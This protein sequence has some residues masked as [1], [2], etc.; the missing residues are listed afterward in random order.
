MTEGQQALQ[1]VTGFSCSHCYGSHLLYH[2]AIGLHTCT[3]CAPIT[4]NEKERLKPL[5]EAALLFQNQDIE[6]E[7]DCARGLVLATMQRPVRNVT[8]AMFLGVGEREVKAIIK[9]LRDD[10]H[11]PIGSL[12]EPPYGYYWINSP[13]EF[14]AW[15]EPMRSQAMSELRTAYRLMRRHYPHLAGQFTFNFDQE[16]SPNEEQA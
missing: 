10:W 11:L 9:T 13:E 8:L 6:K 1:L 3:A 2:A 5:F 7:F 16:D 15:F 4:E 12:R 14:L